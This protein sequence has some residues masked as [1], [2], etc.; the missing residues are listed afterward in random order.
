MLAAMAAPADAALAVDWLELCR[1]AA[2]AAGAVL[3]RYPRYADR[4]VTAGRGMG[5]DLALVIDRAVEDAVF[6]QLEA[7]GD[8][9][10]RRCPRSAARCDIAGGGPVHVVIDPID[11]SRNAK[12]GLPLLRA[13]DRGRRRARRWATSSSATSTTSTAS[14]DWWARRGDGR[15]RRRR[16][17]RA[18]RRR[19]RARDGRPRDRP[20]GAA[21]RVT[22]TLIL[23]TGAARMRAHRVDRAVA[24]LRRAARFDGM[25]SARRHA[26]GRLRRRPAD[27]A[28]GGRRRRVPRGRRRSARRRASSSTM[29]SRVVAA[30]APAQLERLLPIGAP[31]DGRLSLRGRQLVDVPGRAGGVVPRPGG[32][33]GRGAP[34]RGARRRSAPSRSS[35]STKVARSPSTSRSAGT[36]QATTGV[37]QAS[38]S[39]VGRPKPS[40]SDGKTSARAP[41]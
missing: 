34:R 36:S 2:E 8:P 23:A 11:G 17:A 1:R 4:A 30:A 13:V 33:V 19:R 20:P 5:G 27:R 24:L 9:A 41:V 35:A 38:A 12:R 22:R 21:R 7:L 18:A 3:D 25:V 14:E 16:A 37:P 39:T 26:L 28:R 40:S 6:A 31:A 10:D 29:R 15:V 32:R